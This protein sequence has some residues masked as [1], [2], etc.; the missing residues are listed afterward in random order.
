MHGWARDLFPICRSLTGDGVRETLR[1]MQEL[2]PELQIHEIASG[3]RVFDWTIPDE[4][5]ISDAF[6][7]DAQGNR[8]IDFRENNLHVVG[9][10]EPIDETFTRD[11]LEPHLHSLPDQPTAIPYVT[12]YYRRTWG[13]CVSQEQRAR[14]GDGPFHVRIDSTLAP[15]HL[16]YADAILPGTSR[17]EVLL[18]TYVCH[19]S[20][21]NNELSG[22]VVAMA[23][24]R[25]LASLPERRYAYRFV[26]APETIGAIAYMSLHLE[27]LKEFVRVGWVL[28]C[29]GDDRTFSYVPSRY[30]DTLADRVSQKVLRDSVGSYVAYTFLDRGSDE[31]QWCSPGA[32]LPVCS[33]MR[34]KYGEYPEYHTSLDDLTV[35]TP[36]GL[37]GAANVLRDCIELVE[38]NGRWR[39]VMPGEPQLGPRGLYPTTSFKGSTAGVRSMMDVLA[40]CDGTNDLISL[41]ERTRVPV[42]TVREI[43]EKLESVGVVERV[44]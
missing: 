30:G 37:E 12:S 8:L 14:L 13:F 22:P 41:S 29:V 15:G 19:P 42:S 5:N 25:W 4:W 36:A 24:A 17:D 16:T 20:M 39:S 23:L 21:A 26:V 32:E 9:Y 18:S 10:S 6:V 44:P 40:Y 2:V 33:V 7:A 28:T 43:V 35:V 11:E 3:T 38:A 1:Y 34:S 27:H 31:R